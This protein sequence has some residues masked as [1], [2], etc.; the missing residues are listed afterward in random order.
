[1]LSCLDEARQLRTRMLYAEHYWYQVAM[2]SREELRSATAP[3]EAGADFLAE[4]A[5]GLA[6]ITPLNPGSAVWLR[7]VVSADASWIGEMLIV[8]MSYFPDLAD[9]A[10][11]AGF[12]FEREAYLN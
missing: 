4:R 3:V 8:E 1:M 9:A 12:R 5:G 2:K 7:S 6:Q 10:I 11:D